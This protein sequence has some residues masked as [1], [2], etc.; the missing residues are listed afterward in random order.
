MSLAEAAAY[1][2]VSK[3]TVQRSG[4]PRTNIGRLP[5]F[6]REAIDAYLVERQVTPATSMQLAPPPPISVRLQ[7]AKGRRSE[8]RSGDKS[9]RAARL[10]KL[11]SD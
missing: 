1:L 7:P 11:L 3:K 10:L 2:G 4:I 9:E 5:R 8:H 6:S